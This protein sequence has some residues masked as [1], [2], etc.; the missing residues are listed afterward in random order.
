MQQFF[1]ILGIPL[2]WIL[3]A[4]YRYISSNYFIAIALFTVL[5]RAATFPFSLGT[6]KATAERARL[7]P[8]LER[9]Q[10]KYA[11][12][13]KKLQEKQMALYEKEGV[14]MTAGCLPSVL[15][16]IILF[17]VIAV[18]Y[19]PLTNLARIPSTVIE[20]SIAAVQY[21][22]TTDD[23]GK[24][25]EVAVPNKFPAKD[26]SKGSYYRELRLLDK[27]EENKD[28]VI[29]NID[30]LSDGD[31]KSVS[32]EDYYDQMLK[33]RENFSFFGG[34]TLLVNPWNEK[35]FA[36]ISVLWL[37]PL[38][39]WLTAM[40]SSLLSMRYM[41]LAT[42]GEKQPGQGCTNTMMVWMMP[43]FS[44]FITF[45]VPGGVGIYWICS[46]IIAVVQTLVLNKIYNPVAIRAKA[47]IEYQERRK[48]KLEDK[49][50]IAD[51]HAHEEAEARR[52]AKEQ[53]EL[54]NEKRKAANAPKQLPT[55]KNP[56]KIKRRDGENS[57]KQTSDDVKEP[58]EADT[59][60]EQ[61][62][63]EDEDE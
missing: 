1:Q 6:Q 4:I 33:M 54:E 51:A 55:S 57:G 25:A 22:T 42:P 30:A 48:Q 14:S 19:L 40:G 35:G 58:T 20:T 59:G 3:W 7:A 56:N 44:L 38:I 53:K 41:N 63:S 16:M 32:G 27:L 34:Q 28:D 60:N 9:L 31:R 15:Q 46:N 5:I 17:G 24:T 52:L 62:R 49:K 36:G 12:D 8:R 23:N 47:E 37:I 61:D 21:P 45:T 26:L 11:K 13:P 43:L 10:K 18:I 29:S 50:R 39:S 2:G